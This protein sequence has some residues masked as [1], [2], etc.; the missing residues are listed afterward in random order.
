MVVGETEMLLL[1]CAA[2]RAALCFLGWT[3]VVVVAAVLVA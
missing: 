2:A 3:N 1:D